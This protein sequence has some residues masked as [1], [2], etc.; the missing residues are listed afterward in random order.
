[1]PKLK[2]GLFITFEGP[3]GCGKSTQ[4]YKLSETLKEKGYD[5]V[6]TREPGGTAVGQQI[7]NILL[8]PDNVSLVHR[9][10][11]LMFAADRVQ[12][13]EEKV[14]PALEQKKIVLCDRYVDST[15]A[16][17]IGGRRISK[18]LIDEINQIST[19]NIMPGLTFLLDIPIEEGLRRATQKSRD[20]F[21]KEV[22]NFHERV[23]AKYLEIAKSEPQRVKKLNGLDSIETIHQQ[24]LAY[25]KPLLS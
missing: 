11:V 20:R 1:M 9:T 17:Q 10:E 6:A 2:K 25:L 8:S 21:E 14:L 7:R 24:V 13:L 3:E 22:V 18:E 19:N 5:V 4:V 12:H 23:R 16:Y 15:T